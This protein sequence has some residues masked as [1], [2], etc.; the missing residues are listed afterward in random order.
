MDDEFSSGPWAG[1]YV[2]SWGLKE[3]M[4][5]S[6][7]FRDGLVSG[8]G[9]DPVGDFLIKGRYD[10]ESM[11]IWWTKAYPGSHDVFYKGCRDRHGIWG[12]WELGL[13][14]RGGF[15]I[16]P[17]GQGGGVSAHAEADVEVP[18]DAVAPPPPPP[19]RR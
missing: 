16:W 11:D 7:S 10:R 18:V 12:T 3:P 13:G 2:Y 9:G 14:A 8:S 19:R 17:K 6:L 1:F 15:H 4:D 5:L